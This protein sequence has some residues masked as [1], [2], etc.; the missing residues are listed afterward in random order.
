MCGSVRYAIDG[1]IRNVWNCHCERCRRWTGHFT[2]AAGCRRDHLRLVAEDTLEW[3]YPDEWPDVAYGFCQQCGS[4]LFWKVV[5]VPP[6]E[7]EQQLDT[8]SIWAGTLDA[9]TG[10][11]TEL[12]IH[13]E[14]ASDYHT[15][16]TNIE[17]H[18]RDLPK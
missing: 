6:G 3:F 1:P 8:I 15:L 10:L 11:F 2:A 12:A 13:A 5:A 17:T 14:D 9:P 18:P 4:S 16:D 7:S